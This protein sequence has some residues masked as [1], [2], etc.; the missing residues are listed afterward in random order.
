MLDS[1]AFVKGAVSKKDL[2]PA[3]THFQIVGGRIT[4]YN[5]KLALSAPI[6]LD[7]DC[8]PKA[9]PFI[10]AV[11]ACEGPAQLHLTAA[12][13]LAVRAGKFRAH[14]ETTVPDAFPTIAPEGIPVGGKAELLPALQ[15][16][17]DF[18]G[19]DVSRPWASGVLFDGESAFATNNVILAECWLGY[20]FPYRVTIPHFAVKELLRIGEEPVGIQLTPT[21]ATFHFSGDRWLRTQLIAEAWPDVRKLLDSN[22]SASGVPIS[23]E[24]WVAMETLRPFL[25]EMSRV[26][27]DASTLRT[28]REDDGASFEVPDDTIAGIY[29]H[30]MLSLLQGRAL[31]IDWAAYPNRV[32]WYGK[33]LRGL[34]IGM[35]RQ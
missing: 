11:A 31:K 7:I 17:G 6:A 20:H 29:H 10:R 1:L 35:V 8:C 27:L 30:A 14:I 34:I 12:G 32:A 24:F 25:D 19:S 3:L 23:D 2:V 16:L 5:G 21:N 9:E 28:S 18:I 33:N 4:G 22:A 26:F 13:K 15:T